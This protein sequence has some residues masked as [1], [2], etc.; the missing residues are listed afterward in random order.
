M[1]VVRAAISR[2][3]V[4]V[5]PLTASPSDLRLRLSEPG[6]PATLLP[7]FAEVAARAEALAR[8]FGLLVLPAWDT[9]RPENVMPRRP[10]ALP[11]LGFL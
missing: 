2:S 1:P 9:S 10:R 11:E 3:E 6:D 7:F 5:L 8:D 4:L